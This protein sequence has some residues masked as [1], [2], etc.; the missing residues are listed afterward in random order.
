MKD[1]LVLIWFADMLNADVFDMGHL[2]RC[3]ALL[4]RSDAAASDVYKR[5]YVTRSSPHSGSC[6]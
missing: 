2:T 6:G 4:Q 5:Q 3:E 1:G